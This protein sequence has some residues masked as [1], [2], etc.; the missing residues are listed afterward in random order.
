[1]IPRFFLSKKM[2]LVDFR[3]RT[4]TGNLLPYETRDQTKIT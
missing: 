3:I 4:A 2:S 1:M